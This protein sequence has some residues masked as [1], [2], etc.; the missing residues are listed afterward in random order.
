MFSEHVGFTPDDLERLIRQL[1][2]RGCRVVTADPFVGMLSK[3]DPQ[4]LIRVDIPTDHPQFTVEQLTEA[5]RPDEERMRAGYTQ[6][7]QILRDMYHLYPS[8]CDVAEGDV[9]ETDARNIA[10]FNDRLLR[11]APSTLGEAGTPHWL[12]ILATPDHGIQTLF[13]G[14][15]FPDIV[16]SKLIETLAAGRH[17]ILIGPRAFVDELVPRM[18]TAEGIDILSHC[19]FNQFY[20]LLLS[21]EHVF[22]WN[23]VSHSLLIRLYNQL[24]IVQFD[25]GHLVRSA[26]GIYDRIVAWYYQGWKPPLR[27]HREPLTLETVEGWAAEYRQQAGRLLERY[28]RAPSPDQMIADLMGRAP[29]P[30][31]L[32]SASKR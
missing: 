24:P 16:A 14:G 22:Y 30:E 18:P 32:A 9:T 4:T 6:S 2:E 10:F 31:P 11:P 7:E 21:A 15:A 28:R 8:Y 27:D 25:R 3:Q 23:V 29:I 5:K 13:E 26:P 12:F 20:S 19:P 1:R 17:P